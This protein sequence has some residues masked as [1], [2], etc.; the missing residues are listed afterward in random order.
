MTTTKSVVYDTNNFILIIE[1]V[2][3]N[4]TKRLTKDE[5]LLDFNSLI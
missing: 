2:L 3:L 4:S 5:T 1:E